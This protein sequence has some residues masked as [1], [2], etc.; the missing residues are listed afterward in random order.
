MPFQL[1]DELSLTLTIQEWNQVIAALQEE[2]Q[3]IANPII[4]K[5]NLQAQQ[6][7]QN[8]LHKQQMETPATPPPEIIDPPTRTNGELQGA[9]ITGDLNPMPPAPKP[10]GWKDTN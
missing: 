10:P 6:H 1:T 5:I 2:K 4:M 9:K 7:E 8:Q 3:R